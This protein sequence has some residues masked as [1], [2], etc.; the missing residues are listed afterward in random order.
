M[1]EV[2]KLIMQN[3][4]C[5]FAPNSRKLGETCKSKHECKK[6][7]CQGS[8]SKK[9]G[10]CGFL[11]LGELIYEAQLFAAG[12]NLEENIVNQDMLGMENAVQIVVI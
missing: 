11:E 3:G 4:Y 7:G 1:L 12:D 6:G 2:V 9:F 8:T 10:K 5:A